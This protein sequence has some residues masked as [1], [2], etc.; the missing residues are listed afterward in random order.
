MSIKKQDT[1]TFQDK[2]ESHPS[3]LMTSESNRNIR[4]INVSIISENRV[5]MPDDD[6][7]Y[8]EDSMPYNDEKDDNAQIVHIEEIEKV[9]NIKIVQL[10]ENE[11]DDNEKKVQL[12]EVEKVDNIKIAHFEKS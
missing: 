4:A 12:E 8:K 11:E 3:P 6:D 2:K 5:I 7:I 10:E 1:Y 9:D